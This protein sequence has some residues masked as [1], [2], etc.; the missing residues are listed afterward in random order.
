MRNSIDRNAVERQLL[1]T[2]FEQSV[3][4]QNRVTEE[5]YKRSV[6]KML[7]RQIVVRPKVPAPSEKN[8][9]AAQQKNATAAR[10]KIDALAQQLKRA[11]TN[12]VPDVFTG[13]AKAQSDDAAT[14]AKGGLL[15][16]KLPTE[17]TVGTPI[18]E[19]LSTAT[20]T[21]AIVGPLQDEVTRDFYLFL[22]ENRRPELPKDYAKK[23][24]Q[25][26]KD[27]ETQRD[28]EAWAKRQEQIKTSTQAEIYD[29]A[30]VAYR[31]QYQDALAAPAD[32]QNALRQEALQKYQEALQGAGSSESAAIHY[33]MAQLYQT[34]NH[35]PS[36]P[37]PC[38]PLCAKA[39]TPQQCALNWH[40]LCAKQRSRR[41]R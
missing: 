15:G 34:L 36:A 13:L 2:K 24:A 1:L 27:Y 17:L 25:L 30:L 38:K 11:K 7:L 29:P 20:T 10:G 16:W 22:I 4:D 33:Q 8:F 5:D 39:A 3:K 21:P 23:K 19:A 6:S 31:I 35:R 41:K 37:K 28:N 18:K 32:Q 9:Q 26:L 40:V 14:K 12:L